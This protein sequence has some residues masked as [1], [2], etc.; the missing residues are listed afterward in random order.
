MKNVIDEMLENAEEN[1]I[2]DEVKQEMEKLE[3]ENYKLKEQNKR[4]SIE[5]S[6]S[7]AESFKKSN[8]N[9]KDKNRKLNNLVKK[10]KKGNT[11]LAHLSREEI[12]VYNR[13]LDDFDNQQIS[14]K[15]VFPGVDHPIFIRFK[16]LANKY[17]NRSFLI[18]S[19]SD[20]IDEKLKMV[21]FEISTQKKNISILQKCIEL[22]AENPDTWEE[23]LDD[24]MAYLYKVTTIED[25]EKKIEQLE[26]DKVEIG[27]WIQI[28]D[29]IEHPPV[30]TTKKV[31][32]NLYYNILD[33]F[34]NIFNFCANGSNVN[35]FKA[36]IAVNGFNKDEM[37][38]GLARELEAQVNLCEEPNTHTFY[39]SNNEGRLVPYQL[40]RQFLRHINKNTTFVKYGKKNQYRSG[41]V[42]NSK[43]LFEEIPLYCYRTQYRNPSLVGFNNCF[44]DVETNETVQLN[45]SVPILPLK[46]CNTE[47]Y[48]GDD[49]EFEAN[50]M[51]HIFDTC[52]TKDDR[53]SL[54]AYIGCCLYDKGYTSRQESL[55]IMG[56][57][58]TGKTTLTKAICSIFY[59]VGNQLVTKLK[60]DN[61]FGFSVFLD[62]DVVVIDEIQSAK[63]EFAD[64]LKNISSSDALPVEKKHFDTI[65]V[66]AENVP[67]VFFIGN[68][69]SEKL[70]EASDSAGVSRRILIIMPTQPIQSL[71]YQWKDLIQDSCKQWLVH[72]ATKEYMAQ[73]LHEKAIPIQSISEAEKEKRLLLC[74]YP[75]RYFIKEHFE[76]I[77]LDS[78]VIDHSESLSYN[79]LFDFVSNCMRN[80]MVESVCKKSN[81]NKFIHELKEALNLIDTDYQAKTVK[82]ETIFTGI[83]AK[84]EE[85]IEY[86]SGKNE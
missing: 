62:S 60:D 4:L 7:R 33:E 27:K 21:D 75:E 57:G 77:Y 23:E 31:K 17:P 61:E 83:K 71:G 68:N 42:I 29:A 52:F 9:L 26:N 32:N 44:Y 81:K 6:H 48:I 3:L 35:D 73:G 40:N 64:K 69:F 15:I 45:T 34:D 22:Q 59:Q 84:S 14:Q 74:T 47:L 36:V 39:Y 38:S 37:Y 79:Q 86:F 10:L 19:I 25:I 78:G 20:K 28:K 18:S 46:N 41:Q 30:K 11:S 72:E 2:A 51:Q 63:K 82:G 80:Q 43:A 5:K 12:G 8:A 24:K 56:K 76:V 50:P 49:I 67:R 70:Y 13:M 58:G 1:G 55:F 66:P 54:L 85:A 16:E 65:N 53:K